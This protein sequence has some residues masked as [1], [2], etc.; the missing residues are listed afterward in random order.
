MTVVIDASV[1]F[2]G[3]LGIGPH[4][5]W[6]REILGGE[7]VLAPELMTIE[8]AHLMR[9]TI[10]NGELT[11]AE[12]TGFISD[13]PFLVDAFLPHAPL[14]QRVW[15]LRNNLTSYDAAYV[16]LA[17]TLGAPLATLDKRL[18]EAPGPTCPFLSAP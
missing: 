2:A 6:A 1:A 11:E 14:L 9:K 12:A 18:F 5:L 15:E 7:D 10:L 4:S 3:A 17:E 16:A 13:L 8:V